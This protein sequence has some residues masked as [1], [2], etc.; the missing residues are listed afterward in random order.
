MKKFILLALP[1][2]FVACGPKNDPMNVEMVDQDITTETESVDSQTAFTMDEIAR[3]ADATSCYSAIDGK[4]YDLTAWMDKHPGG[5]G[6]I[7]KICGKDG[8]AAFSGKHGDSAQAKA[9]LPN[10]YIGNLE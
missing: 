8:S 9:V 4:V 5:A 2:V 1:F 10:Y 6:N 7:L 3:H